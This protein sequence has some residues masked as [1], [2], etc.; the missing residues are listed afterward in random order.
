MSLKKFTVAKARALP[1]IIL[2]DTS[3][4]MSVD[5][6]IATLNEA[7]KDML[8]TFSQ[9]S[10]RQAEIKV[11]LITFGGNSAELH[12]P[13]AKAKEISEIEPLEAI[14]RTPMGDAFKLAT[15]LLEDQELLSSRDYRPVLLLLSD[16]IPT[17]DW[18]S[19]LT[20]LCESERAKKASR[21]AMAIGSEA[22]QQVLAEFN[23]DLEA[24][25]F[26]ANEARDIHRF[27]RAVTMSVTHRSKSQTPNVITPIDFS[28]FGNADDDLGLDLGGQW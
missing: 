23:N 11:G 14:G 8:A 10:A 3:G 27:F 12:L 2:A 4:S 28:D 24:P 22:D 13:F 16:G 5:G 6:K 9:E 17:D 20:A 25:V 1:V 18:K 19:N 26:T 15:E 7:V 21:F